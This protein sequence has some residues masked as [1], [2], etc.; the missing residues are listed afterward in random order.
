MR[1]KSAPKASRKRM[2]KFNRKKR[3]HDAAFAEGWR[4]ARRRWEGKGREIGLGIGNINPH[5]QHSG[6]CG[7]YN[8]FAHAAPPPQKPMLFHTFLKK[9]ATVAHFWTDS[10]TR[11]IWAPPPGISQN[12]SKTNAFSPFWLQT[13]QIA[14]E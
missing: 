7:G 5:A 4:H 12:I 10:A 6:G 11:S 13:P 2:R 14:T 3:R 9:N 8:S 1:S